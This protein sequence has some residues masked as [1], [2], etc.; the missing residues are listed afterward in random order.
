MSTL[1]L[2]D[3]TGAGESSLVTPATAR[4]DTEILHFL[5]ESKS[6]SA[7][8]LQHQL[9][10]CIALE[11]QRKAQTGLHAAG[12]HQLFPSLSWG[13][14]CLCPN[15]DTAEGSQCQSPRLRPCHA[16]G[17]HLLNAIYSGEER[18]KYSLFS[19]FGNVAV[20]LILI[21]P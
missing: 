5:C 14:E 6:G 1:C 7:N 18:E 21:C 20:I 10:H 16:Q 19:R 2:H 11:K 8:H 3:W 13:C 4:H 17:V 9:F 15:L 12:K